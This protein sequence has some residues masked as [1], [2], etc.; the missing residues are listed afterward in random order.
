MNQIKNWIVLWMAVVSLIVVIPNQLQSQ[1]YRGSIQ[2]NVND[3]TGA[4]IPN[5]KILIK[6]KA[7]NAER[8]IGTS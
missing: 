7:T 8:S 3:P 2:G 5:A 1:E 6:N 4:L